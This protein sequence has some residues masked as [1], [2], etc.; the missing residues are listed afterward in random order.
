MKTQF[1]VAGLSIVAA[2]SKSGVPRA[3]EP[4]W[5]PLDENTVTAVG[6]VRLGETHGPRKCLSLQ[7]DSEVYGMGYGVRSS[8]KQ[9]PVGA[10]IIMQGEP[11]EEGKVHLCG[12]LNLVKVTAWKQL[13]MQCALK[14]PR[15]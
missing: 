11:L 10:V 13:D 7:T 3:E 15:K 4:S 9:P 5:G 14:W 8:D 1:I 2:L 12:Q 6:C